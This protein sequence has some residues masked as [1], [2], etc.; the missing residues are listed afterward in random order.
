MIPV[1]SEDYEVNVPGDPENA[2]E[3]GEYWS[4]ARMRDVELRVRLARRYGVRPQLVRVS[5]R[6]LG[7]AAFKTVYVQRGALGEVVGD[8]T[9]SV[10]SSLLVAC[11][12]DTCVCVC[13]CVR[14][15]VCV[16]VCACVCVGAC[17]CVCV[18]GCARVCVCVC[19][20]ERERQR[21]RHRH[22]QTDRQ[23][24]TERQRER[25]ALVVYCLWL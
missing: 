6:V 9:V 16:C 8:H 1:T 4:P 12:V 18:C 7:G 20:R 17:V 5:F 11:V 24:E 22:R 3:R 2:V 14:V 13:V 23:T 10:G 21:Q 25:E 15:R 19:E